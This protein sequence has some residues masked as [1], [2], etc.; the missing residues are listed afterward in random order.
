MPAGV[1]EAPHWALHRSAASYQITISSPSHF[2][3]VSVILSVVP[4]LIV[5]FFLL[6]EGECQFW[7]TSLKYMNRLLVQG[8]CPYGCP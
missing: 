5:P 6:D 2:L 8:F 7:I 1:A 4:N 3:P